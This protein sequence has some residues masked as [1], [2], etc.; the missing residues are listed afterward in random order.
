MAVPGSVAR[1]RLVVLLV[2]TVTVPFGIR[3]AD[4]WHEQAPAVPSYLPALEAPRPR[5][6]FN[7]DPIADLARLNPGTS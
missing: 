3:L 6:P 7:P 5:E 1:I 4:A 2:L